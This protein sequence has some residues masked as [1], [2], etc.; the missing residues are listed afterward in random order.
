MNDFTMNCVQ[1]SIFPLDY[2]QKRIARK[3]VR[4]M[5]Q[6]RWW[7]RNPSWVPQWTALWQ[8]FS[9]RH[10]R[11]Q[12]AFCDFDWYRIRQPSDVHALQVS[13][14]LPYFVKSGIICYE[15]CNFGATREFIFDRNVSGNKLCKKQFT[16]GNLLGSI[17]S[18]ALYPLS[19]LRLSVTLVSILYSTWMFV[20]SRFYLVH[21][22][23]PLTASAE[24]L[25]RQAE[26]DPVKRQK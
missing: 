25:V 23:N 12:F 8:V 24:P 9:W 19:V 2:A 1:S 5:Y 16:W 14:P 20:P 11:H 10:S 4:K 18:C 26:P 13:T 22:M 6:G 15:V 21:S 3:E 7:T 17:P